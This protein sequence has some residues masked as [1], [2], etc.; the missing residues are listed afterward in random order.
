ME[1]DAHDTD[2]V[3]PLTELPFPPITK[4]HILHCSYHYW[5]PKYRAVT[6]KARLIE[7]NRPFV[8]Y[9]KADGIIL[10]PEEGEQ[11]DFDSDSGIFSGND[12]ASEASD[13]DNDPSVEWRS[14]HENVISTIAELGGKVVPKLNWSAPKDA[15]WINATNS[16]DCQSPNDIY[17]LLKS[18]DFVTHDLEH[19]YDGCIDERTDNGLSLDNIPY[20]LILRKHVQINPAVEFRCFVR[21]R[22]LMGM[23]QR[24][25]NYFEFL[26]AMQGSLCVKIQ[27]FFDQRLKDTFPDENFTFDVY[28]PPPHDRVWLVDINPW[29]P[30]T[31]PLLY[32]WLEILTMPDPASASLGESMEEGFVRLSI[33][34]EGG[35]GSDAI[36]PSDIEEDESDKEEEDLLYPELRLIR[37]D[38][39]EAYNFNSAQYSAHKLPRD[40]VDASRSG[41]GPMQQFAEQWKEVLERRQQQDAQSGDDDE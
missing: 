21:R 7:L 39:P 27:A 16:M 2:D 10:P 14:I 33:R 8:D 34:K 41:P 29:A 13:E 17:L 25:M 5:H 19:A 3:K 15:T 12:N 35:Q 40:V 11:H 38:D 18:S 4:A 36:S 23:C 20:H 37:K 22:K 6:P 9:L 30:R 26:S 1:I 32:S 31:D 24:D 28:I